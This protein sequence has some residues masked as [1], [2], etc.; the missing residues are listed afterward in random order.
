MTALTANRMG[1]EKTLKRLQF[2]LAAGVHA[3]K[4]GIALMLPN[5]QVVQ[6]QANPNAICIGIFAEEIDNSAGVTTV[7]VNV[8]LQTEK[9]PRWFVND[10]GTPVTTA[11]LFQDCYVLDDA[12]VTASPTN[13]CVAGRVIAVDANL[14]VLVENTF[15]LVDQ[16]QQAIVVHQARA[17][18]TSIAAYTAAAGVLT[19][20][21]VGAIGAQDGVTLVAGDVV[22]LPT[23]KATA[24]KDAG[25]YVVTNPGSAGAKFVLTRPVW[26]PTGGTEL[27]GQM[28]TVGGEGT[29]YGGS[30]WKSLV[31]ASTFVVD[32]TDGAWYPRLQSV[33]TAAM[34]AGVSAANSTLYV[35]PNAQVSALP[36]TPGGTQGIL[37]ISTQTAGKPGTSSLV[38]TSSSGTDTSTVKILVVNF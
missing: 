12:T 31:A 10:T 15:G 28:I 13:R 25:P 18:I 37:R 7:L 1:K 38:V 30:V 20:N 3:Y 19:A 22:L 9:R 23:D 24:A 27:S 36:V 17:V 14:G 4:G 34:T 6:G 29:A 2:P 26:Y 33:T 32:T 16:S 8:E 5:G 35:A 21:A 11:M